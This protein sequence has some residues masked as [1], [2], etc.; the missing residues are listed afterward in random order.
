VTDAVNPEVGSFSSLIFQKGIMG[1]GVGGA[2]SFW[3]DNVTL[4]GRTNHP[5]LGASPAGSK[6]FALHWNAVPTAT[7]T[8][9]KSD[10]MVHWQVVASGFPV[11]GANSRQLT[12]TDNAATN[13]PSF[14]RVCSP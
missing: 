12:Y 4:R 3:V 8:I 14:Y 9:Q 6:S 11:G 5:T 7:Y 10:D 2:A 1:A 13:A